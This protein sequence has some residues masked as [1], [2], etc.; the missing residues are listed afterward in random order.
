M[1][2]VGR[3]ELRNRNFELRS[4]LFELRS[5]MVVW[6]SPRKEMLCKWCL[7][8]SWLT[9]CAITAAAGGCSTSLC[10]RIPTL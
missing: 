3:R 7:R 10:Y 8:C 2:V 5:K 1:E 9:M 4:S 6:S